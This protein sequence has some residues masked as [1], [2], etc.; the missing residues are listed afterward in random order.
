[1]AHFCDAII[2]ISRAEKVSALREKIC[3][4]EKLRVIENGIDIAEYKEEKANL[5]IPEDVF[6]VGMVD[7][8]CRQKA[9][10]VFVKM[11]G[12]VHE[13]IKNSFL[14]SLAMY[15]RAEKKREKRLRN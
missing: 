15:L 6:V 11:A 10:D 8:I 13:E 14:L 9:P 7:R 5:P 12:E 3:K 2:C 1:M 4:A